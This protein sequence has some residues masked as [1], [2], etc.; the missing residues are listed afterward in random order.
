MKTQHQFQTNQLGVTYSQFGENL[1]N[2]LQLNYKK[3]HGQAA[4]TKVTGKRK[5][6][7]KVN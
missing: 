3:L 1:Y 7:S 4:E 6:N 2:Q 5:G